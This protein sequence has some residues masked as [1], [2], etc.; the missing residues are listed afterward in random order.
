LIRT[1]KQKQIDFT[2][3]GIFDSLQSDYK[4][5]FSVK[6]FRVMGFVDALKLLPKYLKIRKTLLQKAKQCDIAI[7]MDSSSFNIPL[8]QSL[9]KNP[10]KPYIIYYILPQV[11][12]WKAYRA[13]ILAKICD[14]LWGILPFEDT[15]YPKDANISYV[16]HPLLDTIPFS[17]TSRRTTNLI[18]FMPGSRVAEIRALLP[19]FKALAVI[20][21][22][23]NKQALLIIPKHFKREQ[24][25]KIYG[26]VEEFIL[27]F[28]TYEGL[29]NCEFAF[30]C[31]G[32]ATLETALLGIPTLLV[33]KARIIDFLLAKLLVKLNYIGL[34]NIFLEFF[35]FHSPKNNPNT[36]NFPII[37]EILQQN[38]KPYIL[39]KEWENYD[40]EKFFSQKEIL[41]QY[42][43]NGSAE[44]CVGKIEY[45]AKNL[46]K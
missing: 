33:Y 22:R 15:Y 9:F 40:Y 25:E 44:N 21:K 3:E 24:L 43:K 30:V 13:K 6:E 28:D 36:H 18:A 29:R 32:T 46:L 17:Y 11:W 41:M 8:I 31:S 10:K 45:F 16:G 14:E 7:F 27:S 19:I 38:V 34:A 37:P 2:L 5:L 1:L 4:S 26:N 23:Q 39:L 20:L 42:L 12:A 35:F